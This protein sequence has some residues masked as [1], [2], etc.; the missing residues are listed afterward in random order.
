MVPMRT[1]KHLLFATYKLCLKVA[2]NLIAVMNCR[3]HKTGRLSTLVEEMFN[4][5]S[6]ALVRGVQLVGLSIN[7]L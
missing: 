6:R 1:P 3:V 2:E 5:S 4:F 7:P